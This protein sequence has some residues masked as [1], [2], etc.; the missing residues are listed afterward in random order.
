MTIAT[1]TFSVVAP[2]ANVPG[3][4]QGQWTYADYVAIPDDERYEIVDGVLYT[5]PAPNIGHQSTV[6]WFFFYLTTYI[7]LKHV[8]QVFMAPC[9]VELSPSVVV[10]PDVIVV[11][12]ASAGIITPSRIIGTPD[13]VVEIASPS[14][15]GYDRREKQDAYA[16]AGIREYW[17]A[18]PASG[19]V[20]LL[21]LEGDAYRSK[22]AF[23]GKALLP[24]QVVPNFPVQ[25]EQFFA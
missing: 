5:T 16:Q 19:T 1:D 2:A 17:I 22:G 18:D 10:Q 6:G 23:R 20:E 12:A 9:D 3:P 21:L 24:S 8:G 7:R 14:T 4:R 13:L 11:L 15:A 25:I